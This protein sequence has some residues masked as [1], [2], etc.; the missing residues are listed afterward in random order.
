[1]HSRAARGAYTDAERASFRT[2][3]H[4]GLDVSGDH[5]G[6]NMVSGSFVVQEI[7]IVGGEVRRLRASFDQHCEGGA[8]H[9]VGCISFTAP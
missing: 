5:R 3:G 9:A 4:P 7:S 1:M 2:L 8:T 6:C